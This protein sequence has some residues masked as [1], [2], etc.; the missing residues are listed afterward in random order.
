MNK[1]I[2]VCFAVNNEFVPMLGVCITSILVNSGHSDNHNFTVLISNITNDNIKLL[3][4]LKKI[5]PYNINYITPDYRV[6]TKNFGHYPSKRISDD[7]MLRL[8]SASYMPQSD[9]VISLDADLVVLKPLRELWEIDI[10]DHYWAA[11]V[12]YS[13]KYDGL[14]YAQKI[15][16][17]LPPKYNY[18]NSGVAIFNLK[19]WR[20]DNAELTFRQN[21]L[22]YK[23]EGIFTFTDQDV[24]NLTFCES[25]LELSPEWNTMPLICKNNGVKIPDDP[26]IIHWAGYQKPWKHVDCLYEE[27]FWKY[28]RFLPVFDLCLYRKVVANYQFEL[29]KIRKYIR[30]SGQCYGWSL[31][32]KKAIYNVLRKITSG[33]ARR[34]Y[35][36]IYNDI[37]KLKKDRERI[38]KNTL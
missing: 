36:K 25:S 14:A 5:K 9:K 15:K 11:A 31:V 29:K 8:F 7:A 18:L 30:V 1:N 32:L 20:E 4:D 16:K 33:A 37:E 12:D 10:S 24:L 28:A 21:F 26:R 2:E 3:E 19:K 17:Y 13:I 22:K 38:L 34:K 6:L 35:E 27:F 23:D